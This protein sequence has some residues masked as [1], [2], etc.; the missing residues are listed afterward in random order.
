M[1]A[2]GLSYKVEGQALTGVTST[3]G[4]CFCVTFARHAGY[5]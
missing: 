3:G 2:Q 5:L 4:S 1:I